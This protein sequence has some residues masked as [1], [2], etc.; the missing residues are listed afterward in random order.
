M[1]GAITG[2]MGV[3][4]A[5]VRAIAAGNDIALISGVSHLTALLRRSLDAV[6]HAV[7]SGAISAATIDDAVRQVLLLKARLG[8]LTSPAFSHQST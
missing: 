6:E 5:T 8:L 2:H 1:M 7:A 3:A 4:D